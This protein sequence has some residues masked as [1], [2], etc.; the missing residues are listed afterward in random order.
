[1][2]RE[3]GKVLLKEY[4]TT[5]FCGYVYKLSYGDDCYIGSTLRPL[6]KR[7]QDHKEKSKT[8]N[9]KFYKFIR[10]VG[11][12][13]LSL[14]ILEEVKYT[15]KNKVRIRENYYY[16]LL[17]PSLNEI[18]PYQSP[19]DKKIKDKL[20]WRKWYYNPETHAK[21]KAKKKADYIK[22]REEGIKKI[23]CE[24]GR[25]VSKRYMNEHLK[26][27]IHKEKLLN[28]QKQQLEEELIEDEVAQ[29]EQT[30][31]DEPNIVKLVSR[32]ECD[33]LE[34]VNLDELCM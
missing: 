3:G 21:Q 18:A 9:C 23:N 20:R 29:L 4:L 1:M 31:L 27:V 2:P 25:V 6:K 22:M 15:N 26:S 28:Q 32:I 33:E 34:E 5:G 19:E 24:C 13:N 17:K 30:F 14:E 10:N 7:L 12:D 16:N 8:G 11:F